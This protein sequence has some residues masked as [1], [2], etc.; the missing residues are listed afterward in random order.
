MEVSLKNLFWGQDAVMIFR[1]SSYSTAQRLGDTHRW[2]TYA[3]S[4]K[5]WTSSSFFQAEKWKDIVMGRLETWDPSSGT[6]YSWLMNTSR[7]TS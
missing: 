7:A 3:D 6:S 1:W 4:C 2:N 5:A